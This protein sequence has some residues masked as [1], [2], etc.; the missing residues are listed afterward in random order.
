[1]P[2]KKREQ[3]S[4]TRTDDPD[5][6]KPEESSNSE[7]TPLDDLRTQMTEEGVADSTEPDEDVGEDELDDNDL[8]EQDENDE[9]DSSEDEDQ[10][11]DSDEDDSDDD[12]STDDEDDD[13]SEDEDDEDDESEDEEDDSDEDGETDDTANDSEESDDDFL[14]KK[15]F[16]KLS[17]RTQKRIK[18]LSRK[19]KENEA[20]AARAS[21]ITTAQNHMGVAAD[22]Q[23]NDE[24][25]VYMVGLGSL[26]ANNAPQAIAQLENHL[27]HLRA[28]NK[29]EPEPVKVPINFEFEGNLPD[30]IQELVDTYGMDLKR[31]RIL[32]AAEKLA[33]EGEITHTP[34]PAQPDPAVASQQQLD[35]AIAL[36][37]EKMAAQSAESQ[38]VMF[39]ETKGLKTTDDMYK[40][41]NGPLKGHW[42]EF[43][44]DGTL[45]GIPVSQRV[46]VIRTAYKL[47][48]SEAPRTKKKKKIKKRRERKHIRPLDSSSGSSASSSTTDDTSPLESLRA[49]MV[50][51]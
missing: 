11:D 19:A 16:R 23:L 1:M 37:R 40:M 13:D 2:K 5:A 47:Y 8:D 21:L 7:P 48:E 15:E 41:L 38:V 28:A 3:E 26:I 46:T 10:D 20:G 25:L 39:L 12:D 9:D 51:P 30:D 24:E 27:T 22:K 6:T 50:R 4:D 17:A 34:T 36:E 29:I 18:T 14:P 44:N 43:S 31:A 32:A 45:D 42:E 49:K 35:A 33:K